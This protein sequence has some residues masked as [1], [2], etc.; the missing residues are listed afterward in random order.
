MI[1]VGDS[2][3]VYEV[4]NNEKRIGIVSKVPRT[5]SKHIILLDYDKIT[6]Q[7]ILDQ[8]QK[9]RRKHRL[10][11]FYIFRTSK[12]KY[13]AMCFK[14]VSWRTY[15]TIL[16]HTDCCVNFRF[17]TDGKKAGTL[18]IDEKPNKRSK[19][20]LVTISKP[21]S[22]KLEKFEDEIRRNETFNIIQKEG[23]S[24]KCLL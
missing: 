3:R 21:C 1:V 10:P 24:L 6:I 7:E 17:Y 9:L 4:N 22:R 12:G 23:G 15:R 19:L 16:Y 14:V 13:S 11:A 8:I 20:E 2:G 18:R 5:E